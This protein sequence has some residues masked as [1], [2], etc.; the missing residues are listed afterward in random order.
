M[1][2]AMHIDSPFGALTLIEEDGKLKKLFFGAHALEPSEEFLE[3]P[4]L[5]EAKKQL[6]GYFNGRR[7]YF[8]LPLN[9][10]GTPFQLRVWRALLDI[11]YG[12][13]RS[14]KDV[15]IA[16]GSSK[17]FRA[18]GMANNKNPISI[19]IPC[20]RVI[21]SGGH[22]VGYGGGIDLKERLLKLEG[23]LAAAINSI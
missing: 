7:H 18:V 13:T 15:A 4:L 6:N 2:Y 16:V 17:G 21:G 12:E 19:I 14:Y 10:E 20:H 8:D 1:K 22:M 5:A 11:P 9:P 23:V 3:T